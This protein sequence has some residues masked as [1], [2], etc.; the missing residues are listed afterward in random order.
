MSDAILELR[1]V[2]KAYKRG[3]PSEVGVLNGADL[4]LERG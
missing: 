2:T 1:G 3:T 4:T